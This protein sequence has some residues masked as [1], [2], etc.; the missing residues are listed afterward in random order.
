MIL[1]PEQVTKL[2]E[3]GAATAKVHLSKRKARRVLTDMLIQA[4]AQQWSAEIHRE[5]IRLSEQD[6]FWVASWWPDTSLAVLIGGA[7]DGHILDLDKSDECTERESSFTA[8]YAFAGWSTANRCWAF[9]V[10]KEHA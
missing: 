4:V 3:S 8:S 9:Q 5:D 10:M 2:R 6:G 1:S 7:D